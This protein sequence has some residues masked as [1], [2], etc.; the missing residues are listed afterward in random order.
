MA[1]SYW[2]LP[3]P[4]LVTSSS[5]RQFS[6]LPNYFSNSHLVLSM[7]QISIQLF[8]LLSPGFPCLFVLGHLLFSVP[9]QLLFYLEILPEWQWLMRTHRNSWCWN[10]ENLLLMVFFHYSLYK[11][12]KQYLK[13]CWFLSFSLH[14]P[15]FQLI[16]DFFWA[17]IQIYWTLFLLAPGDFLTAIWPGPP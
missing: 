3:L 13:E 9:L 16:V 5:V 12:L 7:D 6:F 15:Q 2:I 11:V 8:S 10:Y 1:P 17:R 14:H 4:C